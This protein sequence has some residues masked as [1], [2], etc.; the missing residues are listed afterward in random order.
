MTLNHSCQSG[1][2]RNSERGFDLY[3]T[4]ACAVE[5]LMRVERLPRVIW[6]PAAGPGAIVKVLRAHGYAVVASDVID[7]G[8]P[9][10]FVADFLATERAPEGCGA[11][12]TNPPFKIINKF[13]A[14]AL[15]LSPRVIVLAPLEFYASK[16]RTD[17]LENRGLARVHVF[18]ARLPMMHRDGWKGRRARNR[19]PFAWFVW[20]R[21]HNGETVFRRI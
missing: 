4:P 1:R 19:I 14:H 21:G 6:E 8:F 17:I 20:E 12:L 5:A 9:L 18:R 15:D 13:V 7:Y 16:R 11:T 2:H 10:R 3:E